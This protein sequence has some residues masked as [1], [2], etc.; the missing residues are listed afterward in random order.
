MNNQLPYSFL[1]YSTG[2]NNSKEMIQASFTNQQYMQKRP[3]N[4]Q[5]YYA[6]CRGKVRKLI[7]HLH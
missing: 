3:T 5:K 7:H 1:E 6:E 2:S 4:N